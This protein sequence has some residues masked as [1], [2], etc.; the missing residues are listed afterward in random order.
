M[1]CSSSTTYSFWG[2]LKRKTTTENSNLWLPCSKP[3]EILGTK[4]INKVQQKRIR[5]L[6][7]HL[8]TY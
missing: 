6:S 8:A 7:K 4:K 2:M 3:T 5:I 1:I